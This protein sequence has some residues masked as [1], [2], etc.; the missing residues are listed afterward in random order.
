MKSKEINRI[1]FHS[2]EDMASSHYLQRV[3]ELLYNINIE[4]TFE[5]NDLLEFYH[6]KLYFDNELFLLRWDEEMKKEFQDKAN[7]LWNITKTFWLTINDQ[8]ILSYIESVGFCYQKA[9]WELTENLDT[10]KKICKNTFVSIL[11]KNNNHIIRILLFEKI[12]RY[13]STEIRLFLLT[14]KQTAELLLSQIEDKR[15]FRTPPYHFP[16]CLSPEDKE[17]I[18]LEYID[19]E[20]ANL[21]YIRLIE[22]SKDLRLSSKTKLKAQKKSSELNTILLKKNS[23]VPIRVEIAI[24]NEQDE[25]LIDNSEGMSFSISY[26]KLYLD[27]MSNDMEL[28]DVFASLFEF[29]NN[30]GIID[31]VSRNDELIIFEKIGL[32]S[33]Y[34]YQAGVVFSQKHMISYSQTIMFDIYLN[35]RNNSIENLLKSFVLGM[36]FS[37]KENFRL[38]LAS[39]SSTYLEKIRIIAPEL[40]YLLKQYNCYVKEKNIDFELL[41]FDSIPVRFG[42]ILSLVDKKYIYPKGEIIQ[43]LK[44]CFFSDQSMLYYI[45]PYENKY[46]NLYSLLRNENVKLDNFREYQL[47]TINKLIQEGYLYVDDD[48]FLRIQNNTMLSLIGILYNDEVLSYWHY[49]KNI[50]LVID[51]MID[52][53]LVYS[54]NTLLTQQETDYFNFYLNKK[55]FTNGADLRN[56]YLHGTNSASE[57]QHKQ[58]YYIL[59]RKM[60]LVLLKIRDDILIQITSKM[61]ISCFENN[62]ID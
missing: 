8:N 42:E 52:D 47:G 44:Y 17:K 62:P 31:L 22:T 51:K 9:F 34:A 21:N 43:G 5:I 40:E 3:E 15:N 45:E 32:T 60:I 27:K 57:E 11:D 24:A 6:I 7:Q 36:N 61:D 20:H 55:E 58:D 49:E 13:F 35:E 56:K 16:K 37:L 50:R 23:G 12:V 46:K 14:Y 54:E 19:S 18:V 41:E 33:K 10:Y 53:G 39:T 30:Q 2:K 29:V 59:L 28:F 4:D 48:S 1:V 26:G 38:N 25:P